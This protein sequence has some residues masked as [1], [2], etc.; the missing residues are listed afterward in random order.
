ML[1]SYQLSTEMKLL[2]TSVLW[3]PLFSA[4]LFKLKQ[5]S[6]VWFGDF[7]KLSSVRYISVVFLRLPRPGGTWDLFVFVYFLPQKLKNHS[8]TAPPYLRGVQFEKTANCKMQNELAISVAQESTN[9][10]WDQNEKWLVRKMILIILLVRQVENECFKVLEK[11][12]ELALI[13]M[14]QSLSLSHTHTHTHT[15][16]NS[17]SL[18]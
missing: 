13:L 9:R 3:T 18:S 11:Y 8:A 15:H 5:I 2:K 10:T 12:V 17:P 1:T 14:L 4:M 7:G 6:G 16:T